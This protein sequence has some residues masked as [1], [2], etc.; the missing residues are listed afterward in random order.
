MS[1][2]ALSPEQ[3]L[4]FGELGALVL[5]AIVAMVLF[6]HLANNL[7]G[8][9]RENTAATVEG[10]AEVKLSVDNIRDGQ[11]EIMHIQRDILK[12]TETTAESLETLCS[13]N[14]KAFC[15]LPYEGLETAPPEGEAVRG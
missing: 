4:R 9:A 3:F 10:L 11:S 12:N 8:V 2:N 15:R 14:G 1:L 13:R 6:Y 5:L 7:M